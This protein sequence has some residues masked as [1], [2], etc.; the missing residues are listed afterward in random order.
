MTKGLS[1]FEVPLPEDV[2][3][4]EC[5]V[6]GN[7]ELP[8]EHIIGATRGGTKLTI[9][10]SIREMG[11]DGSYGPTKGLR[12]YEKFI[13]KLELQALCLKY[14]IQD[15]ITDCESD[16][17]WAD[18]DWGDT[19]GTYAAETSIVAQGDQSIK[20]TADTLNY[21]IHEV[22]SAS[23]NLTVF[24]NGESSVVADYIG[25]QYYLTAQDITDLGSAH[26][27]LGFHMDAFGTETNM[28]IYDIVPGSLSAGWNSFKIAK[29]AF[30]EVGTGD[31]SAVL[32]VSVK[33]SDSPNAEV[34]FYVDEITLIQYNAVLRSSLLPAIRS[35]MVVTDQTTYYKLLPTL[36]LVDADYYEN[37]AIVGQKL[38]GK[39]FVAILKN[40]LNDGAISL[41]INEKD[42][43][44]NATTFSSHFKRSAKTTVPIKLRTY[45][46]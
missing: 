3:L 7:Y 9:E 30:T 14:Q 38:D 19:G 13:S 28:Y 15:T 36:E 12:R 46:V 43:V 21:G 25:F 40:C 35:G 24:S 6:Y 17:N 31:W 37:I 2:A 10:R 32:G 23:K 41:G 18:K 29:S 27:R 16:S 8:D 34:V 11:Y 4:G 20:G 1:T 22:F 5:K 42:E 45:D 26:L 33:L 44:I 39:A